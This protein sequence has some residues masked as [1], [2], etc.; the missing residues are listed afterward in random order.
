M[1]FR[2][3]TLAPAMLAA[4]ALQ[5]LAANS[6][7]IQSPLTNTGLDDDASGRVISKLGT[8]Q[9]ELLVQVTK[10]AP[11]SAHSI[12]INGIVEATFT[13]DEKG[14]ATVKFKTSKPGKGPT[15]DFDP[16]G[17]FLRV[18]AKGESVLEA[19][20]SS[21]EEPAGAAVLERIN[22]GRV[23]GS[24][25]KA[26]AEYR[27]DRKSRR[28][29]K[30]ELQRAGTGPF[31][32]FVGGQKRGDFTTVRGISR[33]KFAAGSDDAGVLALDFDPRGQVVDVVQA[34]TILFSSEMAAQANGV[35][36]STPRLSASE[37]PATPVSGSG[38]AETKLRIDDRARKHF[39][40]EVENVPA[41]TYSLR[42]DGVDVADIV[43]QATAGGTKGEVEFTSGDDDS[44]ELP[45]TFDPAG[46]T[47]TIA[48]GITIYF[49]GPFNPTVGNG[50]GTPAAEPP[51]ELEESMTSTGL[52]GDAHAEARYEVDDRGRRKFS[53]EIEDVPA[54]TYTL[55]IAGVVR[56]SI[57]AAAASGGGVEGEIEFESKVEPGHRPLNFDPRGQL[58]EIF[59]SAGTFFSHLLGN[60]SAGG[61]GTSVIP[62]ETTVPLLSSGVDNNA[63]ARAELKQKS[64]GRLSFE[65]EAE[66]LDLGSYDL[67]VGGTVRGTLTVVADGN[68]TRGQVEFESESGQLNFAV[69]GQ[70]IVIQ[71]TGVVYF[72][73][74]F[75]AK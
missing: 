53:V 64:T 38:H 73:R 37:I 72:S 44:D 18:L 70:E 9:S 66:D 69:R 59:S 63:S 46:K 58:I 10:L 54:G 19:S 6:S 14:R 45:L 67:L 27:L 48:Q 35:N 75:P 20:L 28:I 33:I 25:G 50:S 43:V 24:T 4:L 26:T 74:V 16:R 62:F 13:T 41:G 40:V 61:G 47:L 21:A 65:V 11:S 36:V 22:L 42:V 31:E 23:T 34:G 17:K 57:R 30:V 60:G 12:E 7:L 55:T 29:F 49:S 39:S 52:D 8:K 1:T 15:L 2:F 51:S 71:K 68:G 3:R 5:G 32:L 56:S